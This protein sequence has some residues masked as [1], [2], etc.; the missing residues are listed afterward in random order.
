MSSRPK[1]KRDVTL[2]PPGTSG[3]R[4]HPEALYYYIARD[5]LAKAE[6]VTQAGAEQAEGRLRRAQS[7]ATTLVFSALCLDT[8]INMEYEGA[9]LPIDDRERS[10]TQSRWLW[11]PRILGSKD[12]FVPGV[13]PY[14]QFDELLSLR[15]GRLVHTSPNKEVRFEG[16]AY[17]QPSF[18]D[19]IK[20]IDKAKRYFGCV[21]GMIE[22]LA[23]LTNGQTATPVFLSGNQ[24]VAMVWASAGGGA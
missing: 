6:R 3:M 5:A 17:S 12:T 11:L 23:R 21:R 9:G 1:T 10:S 15:S 2:Y 24:G 8:F 19:I 7:I 14:Q 4:P 16:K 20:D 18:L 22:E 13:P